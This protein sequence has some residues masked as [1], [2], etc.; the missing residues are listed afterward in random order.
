MVVV[1]V[2]VV[3]DDIELVFVIVII[4]VIMEGEYLHIYCLW[5]EME[6]DRHSDKINCRRPKARQSKKNLFIFFV[7]LG[8]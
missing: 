8:I 5:A 3:V 6:V 4:I 7:K 2:I 1:V